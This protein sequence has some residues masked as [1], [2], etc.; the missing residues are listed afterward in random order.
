MRIFYLVL[1]SEVKLI[2]CYAINK[3]LKIKVL[4]KR[5]FNNPYH[6]R[7]LDV[8]RAWNCFVEQSKKEENKFSLKRKEIFRQTLRKCF[9]Y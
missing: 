2:L 5:I 8:H 3:Y 6:S 1:L 7:L 4:D 9:I